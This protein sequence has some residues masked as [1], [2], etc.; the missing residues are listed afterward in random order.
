ME[1]LYMNH[2][3]KIK[4]ARNLRTKQELIDG[5]GLFSTKGWF[6]RKMRLERLRKDRAESLLVT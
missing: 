2:K 6:K 1:T 5:V 3:Q 4:K